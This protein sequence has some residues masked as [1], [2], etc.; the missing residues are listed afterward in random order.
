VHGAVDAT[1]FVVRRGSYEI[2]TA[3]D[4]LDVDVIHGFLAQSYWSP[5]IPR[6]TVVRALDGS[7]NFGL[8]RDAAQAGF[9]RVVTDGAT[10]AYIADVFVLP[11]HRGA[12]LAGWLVTAALAHPALQGLRRYLLATRD[13][14]AIYA[15]CGFAALAHPERFMEVTHPDLYRATSG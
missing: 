15:R 2:S 9:L 7:L 12:G 3:P 14:H 11:A 10:F 6:E 13:A 1:P 5:D 4:R 8:Y